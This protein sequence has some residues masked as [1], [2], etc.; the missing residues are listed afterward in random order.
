MESDAVLGNVVW[1]LWG[2]GKG[3]MALRTEKPP[4]G[5]E[6]RRAIHPVQ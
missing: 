1:K 2:P 3:A 6:L 5:V 4:E